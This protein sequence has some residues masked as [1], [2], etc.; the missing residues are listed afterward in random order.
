M[1]FDLTP[2]HLL[3]FI[4]IS[5]GFIRHLFPVHY[6]KPHVMTLET[7][8]IESNY[9]YRKIIFCFAQAESLPQVSFWQITHK[10]ILAMLVNTLTWRT[11]AILILESWD[12]LASLN[13][14]DDLGDELTTVCYNLLWVYDTIINVLGHFWRVFPFPTLPVIHQPRGIFWYTIFYP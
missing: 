6:W 7:S 12:L 1:R 2:F 14:K 10:I 11:K 9:L 4:S 3:S 8:V 13:L 5:S